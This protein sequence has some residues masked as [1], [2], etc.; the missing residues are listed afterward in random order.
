[1]APCK[2]NLSIEGKGDFVATFGVNNSPIFMSY[3]CF[4]ELGRPSDAEL[5]HSEF[6]DFTCLLSQCK[7]R[8]FL[9]GTVYIYFDL[10]IIN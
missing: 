5:C 1:M 2:Q 8:N 4:I 7:S 9:L 6:D 3:C 10:L